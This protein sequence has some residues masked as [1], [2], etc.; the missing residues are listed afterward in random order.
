[1]IHWKLDQVSP[2]L[3]LNAVFTMTAYSLLHP[4][5]TCY[6][7]CKPF[8]QLGSDTFATVAPGGITFHTCCPEFIRQ[9]GDR[10]KDFQKPLELYGIL[11]TSFSPLRFL[12]ILL[13]AV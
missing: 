6:E 1:M 12:L 10:R 5:W 11:V 3:L 7:E 4:Y 2:L 8:E 13:T 9:V